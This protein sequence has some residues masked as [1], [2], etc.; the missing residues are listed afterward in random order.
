VSDDEFGEMDEQIVDHFD[1]VRARLD[2]ELNDD[3]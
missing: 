3:E 1:R 2:E